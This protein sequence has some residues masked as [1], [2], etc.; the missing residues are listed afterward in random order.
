MIL[1]G[2]EGVQVTAASFKTHGTWDGNSLGSAFEHWKVC[3]EVT[4][5]NV[6]KCNLMF[7]SR[8]TYR[9]FA[10]QNARLV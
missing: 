4:F 8:T 5:K 7:R 2:G 3:L 9:L 1:F 6:V 10:R